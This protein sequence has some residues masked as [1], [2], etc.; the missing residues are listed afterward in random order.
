MKKSLLLLA[1]LAC[2]GAVAQE[3]QIWACQQVE[4]AMLRWED[5]SWET[6]GITPGTIL[7]TVDGV[8]SER[9]EGDSTTL[10]RC[11]EVFD[12]ITCRGLLLPSTHI[13][14]DPTTGKLG[15]SELYGSL[16]T[17][18]DYRDTVSVEVFNCTKF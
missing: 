3:K 10:L 1:A 12:F 17:S 9:K 18:S 5:G 7:L 4:G 6:Y 14:M 15:M 8:A 11:E 16:S 2:T 13:I